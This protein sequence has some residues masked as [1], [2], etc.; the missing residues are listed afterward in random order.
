VKEQVLGSNE[1]LQDVR[2]GFTGEYEST[3]VGARTKLAL[4][5]QLAKS[6]HNPPE[7]QAPPFV[8]RR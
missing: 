1:R 6:Q 8:E 3:I 7:E 4:A 5:K 2:K